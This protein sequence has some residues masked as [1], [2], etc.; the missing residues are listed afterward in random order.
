MIPGRAIRG[1]EEQNEQK[2]DRW[3]KAGSKEL[4]PVAGLAGSAWTEG[5]FLEVLENWMW[6]IQKF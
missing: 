3:E 6:T 5:A 4:V 2:N 1:Q